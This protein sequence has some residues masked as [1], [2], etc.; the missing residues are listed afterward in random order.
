[1]V[2]VFLGQDGPPKDIKLN[3]I[4]QEFLTKDTEQFNLDILYARDLNSKDLQEK[5]LCLPVKAKKRIV[6][7]K[8]AQQ[9]KA[10]IKDFILNYIK[11]PY[12]K[13]V[14][15]LDI[16]QHETKDEFI[17]DII[18]HVRICRFNEPTR[19]DTFTLTQQINLRR[20]VD[21]LK[22][23]N[24]LLQEGEKPERILGGLRYSWERDASA[25][26]EK[27]KRL[28]L[29]LACDIDIKRGRLKAPIA[30]EKLIVNLCSL[31]RPLV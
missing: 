14:L 10:D 5:L 11:S 24:Q 16:G 22:V 25:P 27:R 1:M 28:Q 31:G 30:L 9:L 15:I 3:S 23:L 29:L 7:V 12:P 20:P 2:Y 19:I 18:R 17:N 26:I 21:A 8:G 6:V 13:V 4:K